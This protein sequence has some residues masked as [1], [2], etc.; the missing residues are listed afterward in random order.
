VNRRLLLVALFSALSISMG[1]ILSS[2]PNV[3]LMSFCVF[4]GGVYTG[5]M[6]GITVGVLAITIYSLFNPFGPP[7][8]QLLIAQIF[9]FATIGFFGSILVFII[10]G[11]KKV[12]IAIVSGIMGFL[13]TLLYDTLT[14]LATAIVVSGGVDLSQS[15][16]GVFISGS[17]FIVL[18]VLS[19]TA[20]FAF[21]TPAVFEAVNLWK[22]RNG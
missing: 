7:L 6:G 22:E 13:L 10:K 3:E 2:V 20:I 4:L 11:R 12:F 5:I 9:S 16:K 17:F 18:H 1:Y 19:N 8:P 15:L 21:T 14:T